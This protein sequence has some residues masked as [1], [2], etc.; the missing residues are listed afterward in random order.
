MCHQSILQTVK[1]KGPSGGGTFLLVI[2]MLMLVM[3]LACSQM[4]I[5][6]AFRG[7][8]KKFLT[9]EEEAEMAARVKKAVNELR[10]AST[11]QQ[12]NADVLEA[13]AKRSL[14]ARELREVQAEHVRR[15]VHD[16]ME[17]QHMHRGRGKSLIPMRSADKE[18]EEIARRIE[19]ATK[20]ML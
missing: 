13:R 6:P 15:R 10:Q 20:G 9:K 16:M 4:S 8:M 19:N 17:P 3:Q 5:D 14:A 18:R 11:L 12:S 2:F 7:R 1:M